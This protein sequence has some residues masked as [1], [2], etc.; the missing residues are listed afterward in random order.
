MQTFSA[1]ISKS[2]ANALALTLVQKLRDLL[3]DPAFLDRNRLHEKAFTRN[4][5]LPFTAVV[6]LVL[7]QTVKSIQN[8]L[9]EFLGQWNG[10]GSLDMPG[11]GAFTRARAKLRHTAYVELNSQVLLPAVYQSAGDFGL[12]RWRGHRV[13]GIDSSLIRL[14]MTGALAQRFGL[15]ECANK[16]GKSSVAFP[17]ARIS[18]LYDVLNRIGMDAHLEPH[19]VAE[20]ELARRHLSQC[21]PED[22]LL[23]DR[24]YSGYWWFA[25]MQARGVNYVARCSKGSFGAV[26]K[27]FAQN[28]AG[29]SREVTLSAPSQLKRQLRQEGLPLTLRVRLVTVRLSTGELEVLATN[30]LDPQRYPTADFALLYHWRW[31]IETYY[32]CL[33]GRLE[34]EH[35]SGKTETSVLQD[36]HA[37]VFVSNLESVI[38]RPGDEAL[39][40]RTSARKFP[41]KLNRAV[42][43]HTIKHHIIALLTSRQP[44]SIVLNQLQNLYM[45]NP[46]IVRPDRKVPR[47]KT[48]PGQS[49]QYQRN[50]HKIVY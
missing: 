31:E 17:Q 47:R 5:L 7:Q 38:C 35:W 26:Q 46:V 3:L 22:L 6:L 37:A 25:L 30:L 43:L 44:A 10:P 27:L 19:T 14:P 21:R 16:K 41:A 42:C 9:H 39:A 28:R 33:K 36:F 49:Y 2:P 40:A 11:T 8:H 13:L 24:G 1:I 32:G 4:R 15:V 12:R 18:V 23:T 50:I 45:A 20:T 34:L 29:V 48:P